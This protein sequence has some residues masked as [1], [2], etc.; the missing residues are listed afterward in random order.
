[1][2][3][4][5]GDE[6]GTP[7]ACS[8]L[9]CVIVTSPERDAIAN[10]AAQC[11]Q[12]YCPGRFDVSICAGAMDAHE[13]EIAMPIVDA[14]NYS[15]RALEIGALRQARPQA[16]TLALAVDLPL[17]KLR[18]LMVHGAQDFVATP[19]D[20]ASLAA[21]LERVSGLLPGSQTATA[22]DVLPDRIQDLVGNSPAFSRVLAMLPRIAGCNA[23]VLILGATGTGKEV[24]A[25]AIHYMS[26]RATR[27]M[28]A[29]N[30]GALPPELIESELFGHTRGAFTTAHAARTGLIR[31]AEGGS[32][33]LDE[34]DS[35][36]LNAQS[37]L[38]RFLQDKEY[39]PVG[40][41]R[42]LQADVRLIAASNRNL[43]EMVAAGTFRQD[44]FFRLHVLSL[45]LP[46]L[47]ERREDIA[48]LS[49][50]F[51]EQFSLRDQRPRLELAPAALQ[52]LL[53]H[54]WPG[55]IRELKHVLERA[56]L[57]ADGPIIQASAIDLPEALRRP[58][59]SEE[60]F[61]SAKERVVESFEREYILRRLAQCGGNVSHAARAAQKNRRAFF[62][63][64]RKHNIHPRDCG[65]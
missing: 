38:L 27:P 36:P 53:D 37:K 5:R 52:R 56:V 12:Q 7:P 54:D 44:L 8:G 21:R 14:R 41:S 65:T 10:L 34:I 47:T 11:I 35:L 1:M 49:V 43:S 22:R 32:L 61:R 63:L 33:F 18:G 28:V 57:H 50:Y 17:T 31:E 16:G 13:C 25:R 45:K 26:A 55:N 59:G 40:S 39:R 48:A 60:S 29:V 4:A 23:S 64:M 46:I 24:C 42:A 20:C 30:C 58:Q 2:V 9:R 15:T 62:E 19:F 3:V 6:R 51:L